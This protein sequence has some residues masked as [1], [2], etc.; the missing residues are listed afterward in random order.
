MME[1]DSVRGKLQCLHCNLVPGQDTN[2][3]LRCK[4]ASFV[5]FE[6]GRVSA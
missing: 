6:T 2:R 5:G 1:V 3:N 4:N